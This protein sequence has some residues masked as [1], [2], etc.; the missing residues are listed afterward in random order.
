MH[1]R[2]TNDATTVSE[3]ISAVLPAGKQ[4]EEDAAINRSSE[5]DA[6]NA[7]DLSH[8][9]VKNLP[10]PGLAGA[11]PDLL[12]GLTGA[13]AQ[14]AVNALD[15]PHTLGAVSNS[16]LVPQWLGEFDYLM[17]SLGGLLAPTPKINPVLESHLL[18]DQRSDLLSQARSDAKPWDDVLYQAQV[19]LTNSW[20]GRS[21]KWFDSL[22]GQMWK[23]VAGRASGAMAVV[24]P[25]GPNSA[26]QAKALLDDHHM[27]EPGMRPAAACLASALI[28]RSTYVDLQA[29]KD[30][31]SDFYRLIQNQPQLVYSRHELRRKDTIGANSIDNR[32]TFS[33][34]IYNNVDFLRWLGKCTNGLDGGDDCVTSYHGML[35]SFAGE[36]DLGT[37]FFYEWG[38]LADLHFDIPFPTQTPVPSAGTDSFDVS[39][40]NYLR[41][42]V[43]IGA[44]IQT[45]DPAATVKRSSRIDLVWED[46]RYSN[47]EARAN[48]W[49][50]RL[51]YTYRIGDITFPVQLLYRS[52]TEFRVES[53]DHLAGGLGVAF[54]YGY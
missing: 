36:H 47:H 42:G 48:Y 8:Q 32:I 41:R 54:S 17:I 31:M 4:A 53:V 16:P 50:T 44:S 27:S 28:A 19:S 22:H 14:A 10:L 46:T 9:V 24:P 51:T 7:G 40:G 38:N 3:C 18:V 15:D 11:V 23:N 43:S 33:S 35:D 5:R 1:D 21:P 37:T 6:Q 30:R 29:R 45:Q 26:G 34:G 49:V 20:I 2:C 13:F 12:P 25:G 52:G 39:G